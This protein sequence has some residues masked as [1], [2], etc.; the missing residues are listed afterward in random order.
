MTIWTRPQLCYCSNV[1]AGANLQQLEHSIENSLTR[2]R[3]LRGLTQ[4]GGGLWI[5]H[6]SLQQ[7]QD[8]EAQTQFSEHLRNHG[9]QLFT[10]NGF[11]MLNF[12]Q[13]QVKQKVYQPDWSS[14]QRS[15]YTIQLAE[16]LA[17]L[18]P[19]DQ[20]SATIS[21]LPL[22]FAPEWSDA[23][24]RQAIDLLEHSLQ[25]LQKLNQATGKQIRLCL[26]M[27]PG[28]VL[29]STDQLIHF[30]KHDL[31]HVDSQL[32]DD[33]LGVCFDICHQAVMFEDIEQSL[34]KIHQAGITIG[35]IQVSSALELTDPKNKAG[36]ETLAH[37]IEPRYLHQAC[38][39]D[40][41][42]QLFKA[43]DL[44]QAFDTFPRD[45]RW[46]VHFHVPI[47]SQNLISP[48][49]STTQNAIG[50][51]LDFLQSHPQLQPH[52]E[53]ETYTWHVLPESL[54]PQNDE[55]MAYGLSQEL[56][57]LENEMQKRGLLRLT[58]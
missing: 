56:N 34:E 25:S 58:S 40:H 44:Q 47:Q 16:L 39:K 54:R 19:A 46:R 26:E 3:E 6:S 21:S 7:L 53:V 17:R 9:I 57:W 12:H 11:P 8:A 18:L 29:E 10:L 32:I 35:K 15:D 33:H 1:H 4:M 43:L 50:K 22:G 20:T 48:L 41:N 28:C 30:F 31:Q 13:E 52:L 24:H 51:T 55:D 2:V 5:N 42:G 37:F 14:R 38:C 36:A 49:L 45:C 23:N 27:E